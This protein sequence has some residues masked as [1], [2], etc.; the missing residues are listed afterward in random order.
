MRILFVMRRQQSTKCSRNNVTC[1]ENRIRHTLYDLCTKKI[2]RDLFY[3]CLVNFNR[4]PKR[5][6]QSC[7]PETCLRSH[8]N[9]QTTNWFRIAEMAI[10]GNQTRTGH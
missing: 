2:S 9:F 6:M 8:L 7:P 4:D 10:R 3:D 1:P 5:E